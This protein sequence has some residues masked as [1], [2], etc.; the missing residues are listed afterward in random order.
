MAVRIRLARAGS[1]GK[2][3]YRLVASDSRYPRDGKFLEQLGTYD[4]RKSPPEVK[5]KH[6]RIDYWLSVGARP[7]DTVRRF[8][9]APRTPETGAEA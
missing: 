4:P 8:L 6:D 7:T 9:K 1:K 3:F 5:I 2:P